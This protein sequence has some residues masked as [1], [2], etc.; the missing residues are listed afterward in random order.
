MQRMRR[1]HNPPK[2]QKMQRMRKKQ[3]MQ[4]KEKEKKLQS[5]KMHRIQ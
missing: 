3:K 1:K 4:R 5:A 2:H